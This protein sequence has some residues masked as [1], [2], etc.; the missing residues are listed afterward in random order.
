LPRSTSRRVESQLV[1]TGGDAGIPSNRHWRKKDADAA[2]NLIEQRDRTSRVRDV[3]LRGDDVAFWRVPDIAALL[4]ISHQRVDQLGRGGTIADAR[5]D[6]RAYGC[7][8]A[9]DRGLGRN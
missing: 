9:G 2:G 4:S 1:E 3:L 6:E 8:A 7:G 5:V